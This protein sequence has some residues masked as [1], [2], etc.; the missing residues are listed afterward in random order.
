MK[1]IEAKELRLKIGE[2]DIV[3][4]SHESATEPGQHIVRLLWACGADIG[5]H[6]ESRGEA[7]VHLADHLRDVSKALRQLALVQEGCTGLTVGDLSKP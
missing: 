4:Y 5:A 3:V 1:V 6:A 7:L 2:E